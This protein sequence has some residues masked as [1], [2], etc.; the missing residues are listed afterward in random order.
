MSKSG[1]LQK[2]PRAK[3][4]KVEDR[5]GDGI[6]EKAADVEVKSA[7]PCVAVARAQGGLEMPFGL[8]GDWTPVAEAGA[9]APNGWRGMTS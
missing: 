1:G 4:K 5:I 9:Q 7:V 8:P 2:S 6:G 3:E